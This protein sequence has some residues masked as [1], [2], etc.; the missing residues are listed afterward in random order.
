MSVET[1]QDT[2]IGSEDLRNLMGELRMLARQLLNCESGGHS[3]TPTALAMTALRRAKRLDVE[4]DDVRW[5]NRRHFFAALAQ[6]MK[7]ALVDH[8]RRRRAK[9]RSSVVYCSGEDDILSDLPGTAEERPEVYLRV[10]E[11]M[12]VVRGESAESAELLEEFYFAGYT[13]PEMAKFRDWSEKTV[14]R[15]IARARVLFRRAFESCG[16]P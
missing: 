7:R 11:A 13:A 1:S 5:E 14:D 9:G 4:W 10:E 16:C 2:P 15:K 12:E 3:L 8:A 6:A